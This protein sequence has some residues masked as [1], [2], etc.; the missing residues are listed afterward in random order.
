MEDQMERKYHLLKPVILMPQ[1]LIEP[2][3][4]TGMGEVNKAERD[5][6]H[7]ANGPEE[8]AAQHYEHF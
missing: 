6:T 5:P 2:L 4:Y 3:L 7:G 8:L 1:A